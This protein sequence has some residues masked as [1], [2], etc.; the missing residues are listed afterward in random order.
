MLKTLDDLKLEAMRLSGGRAHDHIFEMIRQA[1]QHNCDELG[2][3]LA[4]RQK[5]RNPSERGLFDS[6]TLARAAERSA[7]AGFANLKWDD[8]A[9]R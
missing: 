2:R 3:M 4:I 8:G 5:S 7:L 6:W 1:L 9:F